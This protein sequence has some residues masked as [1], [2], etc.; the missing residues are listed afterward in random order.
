MNDSKEPDSSSETDKTSGHEGDVESSHDLIKEIAGGFE[1]TPP[2]KIT[3]KAPAKP[4]IATNGAA[5]PISQAEL[6]RSLWM[7]KPDP[8]S[9]GSDYIKAAAEDLRLTG[10]KG[11]D[12][13]VVRNAAA[14][15]LPAERTDGAKKKN[16]KKKAA[17]S[18]SAPTVTSVIEQP[19]R[20]EPVGIIE[21]K[22]DLPIPPASL[23]PAPAP[24]PE[25][26]PAPL[27][28]PE[29]GVEAVATKLPVV[30]DLP[31][32]QLP[33]AVE[34]RLS[35]GSDVDELVPEKTA[36]PA[37]QEKKEP[38]PAGA[39]AVQGDADFMVLKTEDRPVVFL[40]DHVASLSKS[41]KVNDVP[42]SDVEDGDYR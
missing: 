5:K 29:P 3:E 24:A 27:L 23:Q 7:T 25:A 33:V 17:V 36:V 14:Q 34:K 1:F 15:A 10:G 12:S 40:E 6:K 4:A 42:G 21:K 8:V 11:V 2:A 31:P 13:A 39:N 18:Q 9:T 28:L 30:V 38:A 16:R 26:K 35:A 20:E 37:A 41:D 19:S 22:Q 32:Q